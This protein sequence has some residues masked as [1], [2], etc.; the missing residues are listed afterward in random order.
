M[1]QALAKPHVLPPISHTPR[2][3]SMISHR[4]CRLPQSDNFSPPF[5]PC[6]SSQACCI[7][8]PAL[9]ASPFCSQ[10][11]LLQKNVPPVFEMLLWLPIF[12]TIKT[13]V[14]TTVCKVLPELPS[15]TWLMSSTHW[16]S[17]RKPAAPQIHQGASA[18]GHCNDCSALPR[19]L[20]SQNLH[21]FCPHFL[22]V[23]A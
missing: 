15:L 6:A 14:L 22:R 13:K 10:S 8:P 3:T 2:A 5:Q 23:S 20:F 16:L 1:Q 9:P 7:S 4:S 12:V 11:N 18:Q 21:G 19:T 17:H